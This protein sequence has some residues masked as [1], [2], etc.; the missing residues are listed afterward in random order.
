M[1]IPDSQVSATDSLPVS[2]VRQVLHL[3][4]KP[5]RCV[6]F[7]PRAPTTPFLLQ[8]SSEGEMDLEAGNETTLQRGGKKSKLRGWR[9]HWRRGVFGTFQDWAEGSRKKV[10]HMLVGVAT[11][12]KVV[13]QLGLP[14]PPSATRAAVLTGS[15]SLFSLAFKDHQ[16]VCVRVLRTTSLRS[17]ACRVP[18]CGVLKDHK[19]ERSAPRHGHA[20]R[21]VP[22]MGRGAWGSICRSGSLSVVPILG[23][24]TRIRLF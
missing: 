12:F 23:S 3:S 8:G 5:I 6:S 9:W 24:N 21:P 17:H 13:N 20:P 11:H 16:G 2:H 14:H 19:T 22:G 10:V 15:Y 1:S 4:L 18:L 7:V